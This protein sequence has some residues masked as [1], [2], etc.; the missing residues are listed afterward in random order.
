MNASETFKLDKSTKSKLD[1]ITWRMMED[2]S[3]EQRKR[4]L[5]AAYFSRI[6][7]MPDFDNPKTWTEKMCWYRLHYTH[8]DLQRISD[9]ISFKTY[10]EEKLGPG[11][12]AELYATYTCDTQFDLEAL[13]EQFVVKSS[14]A[15]S[16]ENIVFVNDKTQV[17]THQVRFEINNWLQ[18]WNSNAKAFSNWYRGMV[19]SVLAEEYLQP[20][21]GELLDYKIYCFYGVPKHVVVIGGRFTKGFVHLYDLDWQRQPFSGVFEAGT[22]LPLSKPD[23]FDE[24]LAIASKLGRPFPFVRVDLYNVDGRIVVGEMT[25]SSG[26][27]ITKIQPAELDQTWG[28]LFVLPELK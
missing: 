23:N 3:F 17:N 19:P 25:F 16:G 5:K 26:G 21:S 13:P 9:K 2:M 28:D 1:Y 22:D 14:L 12:T 20:Q 24:M 6:G 7:T 15:T 8:P 18:P 4:W 10:I 27:G 11:Y